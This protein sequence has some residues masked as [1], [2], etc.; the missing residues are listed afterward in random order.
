MLWNTKFECLLCPLCACVFCCVCLVAKETWYW[1]ASNVT[2]MVMSGVKCVGDEMSLAHCRHDRTVSCRRA[3][4]QF[5]AGVIC[6]DS[7]CQEVTPGL[8]PFAQSLCYNLT[9]TKI[10]MT[11]S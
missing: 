7:E 11:E 10:V 3:G 5:A 1:D 8:N 6:S 4:A 9:V 2:E